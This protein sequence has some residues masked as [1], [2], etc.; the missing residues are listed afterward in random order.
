MLGMMQNKG[1]PNSV[2][3]QGGNSALAGM[4]RNNQPAAP[5]GGGSMLP[6]IMAP[7]TPNIGMPPRAQMP[8][9]T[10]PRQ[11]AAPLSFKSISDLMKYTHANPGKLAPETANMFKSVLKNPWGR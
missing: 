7:Q 10:A 1:G 9:Q 4:F 5:G 2:Q 11:Q 6:Q 3:P 8:V